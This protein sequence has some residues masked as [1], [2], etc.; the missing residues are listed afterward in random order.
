[1]AFGLGGRDGVNCLSA[2][3]E[4]PERYCVFIVVVVKNGT[5]DGLSGDNTLFIGSGI[6]AEF[7]VYLSRS[8]PRVKT[9]SVVYIFLIDYVLYPLCRHL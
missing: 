7:H 6:V 4:V 2:E 1:L 9:A 3:V 5:R 8:P